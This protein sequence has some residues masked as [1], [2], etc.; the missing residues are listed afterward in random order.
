MRRV[1]RHSWWSN[2]QPWLKSILGVRA[3]S[4]VCATDGRVQHG[5]IKINPRPYQRRRRYASEHVSG[6]DQRE[7]SFESVARETVYTVP[8]SSRA[9][10]PHV[11]PRLNSSRPHPNRW[12]ATCGASR[13]AILRANDPFICT[14]SKVEGAEESQEGVDAAQGHPPQAL[15][16][17]PPRLLPGPPG[18]AMTSFRHRLAARCELASWGRCGPKPARNCVPRMPVR[19]PVRISTRMSRRISKITAAY[20]PITCRYTCRYTHIYTHVCVHV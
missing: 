17:D 14:R 9:A 2:N 8:C 11:G 20:M 18:G 16:T 5:K 1:S 3:S 19:M 7:R 10:A 15:P 13:P 12:D 4:Q 6:G